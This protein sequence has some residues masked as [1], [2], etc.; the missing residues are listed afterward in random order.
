MSIKE[1]KGPMDELIMKLV[2]LRNEHLSV[3]STLDDAISALRGQPIPAQPTPAT[4]QKK[5]KPKPR[6][7]PTVAQKI[8]R[9]YQY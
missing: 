8:G 3:A 5:A 7:L 4:T 6:D 2:A 1:V 9:G